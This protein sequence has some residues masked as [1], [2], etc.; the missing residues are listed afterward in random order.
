MTRFRIEIANRQQRL[1]CDCGAIQ[2]VLRR[3]LEEGVERAELS[4]AIVGDEEM[5]RLNR[6]FTA[7]D[8][9]TDVLAFPYG[10]HEGLLEGELVI[11]ADEALRQ[12]ERAT[13]G[14]QDEL[15]LYAVHG[16]LHLLGYD[17]RDDEQRK[18]M[19][20]RALSVLASAGCALDSRT[21]LEE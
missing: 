18:G 11:N 5:K 17:D 13:H 20:R 12:A 2:R 3:A 21:L 6:Q 14:P 4:V 10:V 19:H 16:A 9:T 1:A 15:L 7:R 8:R